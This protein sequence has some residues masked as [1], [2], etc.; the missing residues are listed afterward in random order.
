MDRMLVVVFDTEAKAI[1]GRNEL[2]QLDDEGLVTVYDHAT[3][4]RNTDGT[5]TVKKSDDTGPLGTLAGAELGS[6]IG[7]LSGPMGLAVGAVVGAFAGGAVDLHR[8]MIGEDFVADVTKE[9]KPDRFALVAEI[10]EDSTTLV[11]SHMKSIG[12]IV[13]RCAVPDV[14]HDLHEERL[15]SMQADLA[16]LKAVH[17]Q[18][19]AQRRA[20]LEEKINQ[21]DSKIQEQ[22]RQAN[23]RREEAELAEQA[24]AE[25]LQDE[26]EA[27]AA[28]AAA[29]RSQDAVHK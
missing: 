11:D 18:A 29:T 16:Q 26:A 12:G 20:K 27:Q 8:T 14:E 5:T 2:L 3:V 17:A 19:H 22:L 13:F 7:L 25:A 15:A 4:G 24:K 1:E 9:L 6:L 21:L 23:E 28:K 10:Q